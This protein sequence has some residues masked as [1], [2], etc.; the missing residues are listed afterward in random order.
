MNLA[1]VNILLAAFVTDLPAHVSC[2]P[3][4]DREMAGTQNFCVS[5]LVL[6]AVVR[7]STNPKVFQ[8]SALLGDAIA[9]CNALIDH[10]MA[11]LI[12]PGPA[13]WPIFSSLCLAANARANLITDAW[14]AALAIEHNCTLITFDRDFAKFPGL[15]TASPLIGR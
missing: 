4:L 13:H 14:F 10:P 8:P 11:V 7:I 1:D 15:K 9:F 3:W 12:E 2:K 5:T 6:S